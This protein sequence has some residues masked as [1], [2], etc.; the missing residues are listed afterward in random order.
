MNDKILMAHGGRFKSDGTTVALIRYTVGKFN[1]A[2]I[3][4][5]ANRLLQEVGEIS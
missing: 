1:A 2:F 4:N 3:R 5:E